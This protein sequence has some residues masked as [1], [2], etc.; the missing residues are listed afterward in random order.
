MNVDAFGNPFRC[1]DVEGTDTLLVL[2]KDLKKGVTKIQTLSKRKLTEYGPNRAVIDATTMYF[3]S[4]T[5]AFMIGAAATIPLASALF[6]ALI[7]FGFPAFIALS[8]FLNGIFMT[9]KD[10]TVGGEERNKV[11]FKD[12]TVLPELNLSE[13]VFDKKDSLVIDVCRDLYAE[14]L[15]LEDEQENAAKNR[16]EYIKNNKDFSKVFGYIDKDEEKTAEKNNEE[17]NNI[18]NEEKNH[19]ENVNSVLSQLTS[20]KEHNDKNVN[21]N[22]ETVEQADNSNHKSDKEREV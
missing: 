15:N 4:I 8:Y 5:G 7:V 21:E 14:T 10:F 6:F 13:D 11:I 17:T 20:S 18:D 22:F 1:V 2:T 9:K 12:G 16:D 3:F 19:S